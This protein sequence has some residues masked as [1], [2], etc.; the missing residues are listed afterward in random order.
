M[1]KKALTVSKAKII[2][3]LFVKPIFH[4]QAFSHI[5]YGKKTYLSQWTVIE[6]NVDSVN[7]KLL[8]VIISISPLIKPKGISL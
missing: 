3:N 4:L 1:K 7:N 8:V 6:F 2:R 5:L